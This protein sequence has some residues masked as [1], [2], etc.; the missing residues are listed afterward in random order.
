MTDEASHFGTDTEMEARLR[1]FR[2]APDPA[3]VSALEAQLLPDKPRPSRARRG[4]ALRPVLAAGLAA[5]SLA[6]VTA[7]LDLAGL[8]PFKGDRAVEARDNCRTVVVTKRE[9]QPVARDTGAIAFEYRM[10]KRHVERCR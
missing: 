3:F 6:G 8:S 4:F 5:C 2:P 10:V 7:A 9:R 1:N